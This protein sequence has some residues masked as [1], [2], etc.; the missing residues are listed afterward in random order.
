MQPP[1]CTSKTPCW[2]RYLVLLF[3]ALSNPS[4]EP[5]LGH[6]RKGCVVHVTVGIGHPAVSCSLHSDHLWVSV[7]LQTE[8]KNFFDTCEYKDKYLE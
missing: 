7:M 3:Y 8:R 6:N 4:S 2:R 5:F 1:C